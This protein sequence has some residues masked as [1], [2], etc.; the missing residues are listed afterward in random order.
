MSKTFTI[1][2]PT[3]LRPSLIDTCRSIDSQNYQQWQH[4]VV[5][6][7]PVA[8]L[9]PDHTRLI[10]H[11]RHPNREIYNCAVTHGNYGNTCRS[12]MFGLVRGDYVL[13]LDDDDVYLG[14][15]FA[16]LNREISNEV[17]GVFPIER[18]GEVFMNLPPRTNFTSG[19]QFFAKA[20]YPWPDNNV[21]TADGQLIDL[22]RER[23]SYLVINSPPLARI[24][25]QQYGNC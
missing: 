23:H 7:I 20:L 16:T 18:F 24:T 11:I 4:L 19:I 13:Y 1:I 15:A 25:R 9:L 5:V 21:Y 17:W 10:E 6:D 14:E 8:H 2:T 12:E 3:L 22:L